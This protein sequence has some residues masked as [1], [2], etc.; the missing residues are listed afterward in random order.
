MQW[1]EVVEGDITKVEADAIVNAANSDLAARRWGLRRHLQGC[2]DRRA[3]R[4]L[5]RYWKNVEPASQR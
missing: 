3:K 4:S 5:P 1:L 2:R